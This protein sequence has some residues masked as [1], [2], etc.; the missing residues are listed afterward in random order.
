[1]QTHLHTNTP[2]CCAAVEG[3]R[4]RLVLL[5]GVRSW[6]EALVSEVRSV[7]GGAVKG[8]MVVIPWLLGRLVRVGSLHMGGVPAAW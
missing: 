2:V 8:H 5:P 3:Q 7:G 4:E 6:P 1:M